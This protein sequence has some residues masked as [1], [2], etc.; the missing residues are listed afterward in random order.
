MKCLC[1]NAKCPAEVMFMGKFYHEKLLLQL[2]SLVNCRQ[3][4]VKGR[5]F[6]AAP[7]SSLLGFKWQGQLRRLVCSLLNVFSGL[8]IEVGSLMDPSYSF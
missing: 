6:L 2:T 4:P 8:L 7:N 3:L 5:H 1:L